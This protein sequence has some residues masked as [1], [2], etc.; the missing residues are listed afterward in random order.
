MKRI[1]TVLFVLICGQACTAH[2]A[3]QGHANRVED[4]L[5]RSTITPH[6][7]SGSV[8]TYVEIDV[9]SGNRS[10]LLLYPYLEDSD[11]P[12]VGQRCD[13]EY[14][15]KSVSGVAGVRPLS[16]RQENV[17]SHFNCDKP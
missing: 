16:N 6:A 17:A 14:E 13:F 15:V 9:I 5:V 7:Y 10:E 8:A 12:A 3:R 1:G 11:L 2:F 4:A